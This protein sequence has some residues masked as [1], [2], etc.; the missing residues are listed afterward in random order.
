MDNNYTVKMTHRSYIV[1]NWVHNLSHKQLKVGVNGMKV[2][3]L[4]QPY[5][6]QGEKV[7]NLPVPGIDVSEYELWLHITYYEGATVCLQTGYDPIK[8]TKYKTRMAYSYDD[9][10]TVQAVKDPKFFKTKHVSAIYL[11]DPETGDL[12]TYWTRI[13]GADPYMSQSTV[14]ITTH[15][16]P[17]LIESQHTDG[18]IDIFKE[19][20]N[21][22][23]DMFN[24]LRDISRLPPTKPGIYIA[25][26]GLALCMLPNTNWLLDTA[27]FSAKELTWSQVKE[28]MPKEQF[29]L[30]YRGRALW[31]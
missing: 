2:G 16:H 19:M 17:W 1:Y 11:V 27:K 13:G 21:N 3:N 7:Y 4:N 12:L 31:N 26:N 6:Q 10:V 8:V 9:K 30:E 23:T 25:K 5:N 24:S 29:P 22:V 28:C 15:K 20:Q 18:L 14:I